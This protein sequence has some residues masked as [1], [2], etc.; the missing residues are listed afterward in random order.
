MFLRTGRCGHRPLRRY[1]EIF[2][3]RSLCF[4]GAHV[5][6]RVLQGFFL[7]LRRGRCP[8]RPVDRRT[9]SY[10]LD[11]QR[12]RRKRR[13]DTTFH[14]PCMEPSTVWHAPQ[15]P[16]RCGARGGSPETI[17]FLAAFFAYFLPLLAK[18][19]SPKAAPRGASRTP[20]PTKVGRSPPVGRRADVGIGPYGNTEKACPRAQKTSPAFAGDA[21]TQYKLHHFSP[22]WRLSWR[23]SVPMNGKIVYSPSMRE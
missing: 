6:R 9:I 23:I 12:Q 1:V 14:A 7:K 8:H 19:M 4:G 21:S 10:I 22:R 11:R 20:P 16:K 5:S 18:S 17:R 3:A 13:D 15:Q 2:G